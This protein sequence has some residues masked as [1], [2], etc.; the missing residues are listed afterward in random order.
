VRRLWLNSGGNSSRFSRVV[1][2]YDCDTQDAMWDIYSIKTMMSNE[3][4]GLVKSQGE[5]R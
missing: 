2:E 5:E 4:S 1:S 3:Y